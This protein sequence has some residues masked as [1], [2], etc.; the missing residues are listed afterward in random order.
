LLAEEPT[1]RWQHNASLAKMAAITHLTA[2][3]GKSSASRPIMGRV[4]A[5]HTEGVEGWK[6]Q[7]HHFEGR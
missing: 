4:G 6:Q 3:L 7:E 2:I 1:S 5:S